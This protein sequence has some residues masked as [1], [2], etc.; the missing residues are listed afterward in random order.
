MT[1]SQRFKEATD[2]VKKVKGVKLEDISIKLGMERHNFDNIRRGVNPKKPIIDNLCRLYPEAKQFFAA[3][4]AKISEN[5]PPNELNETMVFYNDGRTL[6]DLVKTQSEL[7]EMQRR[8]L[9]R[10]RSLTDKLEGENKA[11]KDVLN[12]RKKLNK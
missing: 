7:I 4:Y 11:L 6:Q 12:D 1:E 9:E 5:P 2:Y 8:E 10:L 3:E